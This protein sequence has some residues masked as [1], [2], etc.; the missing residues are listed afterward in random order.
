MLAAADFLGTAVVTRVT[1]L[2]TVF[3]VVV[4]EGGGGGRG[5]G[6][7]SSRGR[8]R[9]GRE[10]SG[11]DGQWEERWNWVGKKLVY[12]T[13]PSRLYCAITVAQYMASQDDRPAASKSYRA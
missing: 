8:G 7:G 12:G 10:L 3:V 6:R 2:A 13:V 9:R 11:H 5:D 1:N 4:A